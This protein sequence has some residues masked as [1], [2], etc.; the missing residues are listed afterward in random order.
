VNANVNSRR[1]HVAV[2][3]VRSGGKTHRLQ[4]PDATEFRVIA[5]EGVVQVLGYRGPDSYDVLGV[6]PVSKFECAILETAVTAK[7]TD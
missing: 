7:A 6:Y 4:V 5:G 2:V 1:Q 3:R